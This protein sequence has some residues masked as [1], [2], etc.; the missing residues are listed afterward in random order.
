[1]N[2]YPLRP[3]AAHTWSV[4]P[5]S[6]KMT[7][8]L[9]DLP[10]DDTTRE[11]GTAAHW[12]ALMNWHGHA[13]PLGA[14]A[15]NGVQV[16]EDMQD[17]VDLYLRELRSWG[18]GLHLEYGPIPARRIHD[19]ACAGTPDAWQWL[20]DQRLLRV[21][22]FK[23]GYR[24]VSEWENPQLIIYAAALGDMLNIDGLQEQSTTVEFVIVQPRAYGHEPVRR[25]R[26]LMS[27]LRGTVNVLRS[28]A[29]DAMSSH[30]TLRAGPQCVNCKARAECPTL[31]RA[32]M[33][34]VET[35][36][37]VARLEL[38]ADAVGNELRVIAHAM[39]TLEARRTGLEVRASDFIK[40]GQRVPFWDLQPGRG[41]LTWR[42]E[43]A[44]N[45]IQAGRLYGVD[46]AKPVQPITPTQAEGKID[47][48][49]LKLLTVRQPGELKL[50]PYDPN[51]TRRTFGNT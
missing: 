10:G 34:E 35:C 16:T 28:A 40:R 37:Q 13:V 9:P 29:T 6:V 39:Q 25:A 22:D 15:P 14:Q 38:D 24:L 48:D 19:T 7:Q 26:Y 42:P 51:T 3:S 31:Q 47:P 50:T 23:F 12:L 49:V 20:P 45:I 41:K 21:A 18:A 11:E 8:G 30:P 1:M 36:G 33:R 46:L 2:A 44:A 32:T 43:Y 17:G 27:D 5:G 4:C